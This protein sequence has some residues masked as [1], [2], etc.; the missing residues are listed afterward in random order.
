[1]ICL[2]ASALNSAVYLVLLIFFT[3][4][5]FR[6]YRMSTKAGEVQTG[7]QYRLPTEAEWQYACY[8]GSQTEYCGGN[9]LD[10]LGCYN[11]NSGN[12]THPSEQ[13][14]ANGYGLYELMKCRSKL[15]RHGD[16]V[17]EA[18]GLAD[19]KSLRKRI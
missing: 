12:T 8:D 18:R 10:A 17:I 2:T 9:N 4:L 1:M 15:L 3:P 13:K 14:Q 11:S 5:Q 16:V 7:K 6:H 19:S